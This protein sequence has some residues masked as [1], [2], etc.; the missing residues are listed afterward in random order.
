MLKAA[1]RQRLA[2]GQGEL[3]LGLAPSGGGSGWAVADHA[4]A[5]GP[6]HLT[7]VLAALAGSR[8][9]EQATGWS[10][11]KFA[12]TARR[13]RTI[14]I[15]AGRHTITA[16]KPPPGDLRQILNKSTAPQVRTIWPN[17]DQQALAHI[18]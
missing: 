10:I 2:E 11:R 8:F 4:V 5:D 13:Y 15:Q 3:H 9:T 17:L 7:I 6:P 12:R 1:A 14:R 16:A 18:R